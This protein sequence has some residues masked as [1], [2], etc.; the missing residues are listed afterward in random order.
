MYNPIN[1]YYVQCQGTTKSER[2]IRCET[3]KYGFISK[4][5]LVAQ[6]FGLKRNAHA[7]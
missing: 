5:A 4:E 2:G 3:L 1:V 7:F 6:R